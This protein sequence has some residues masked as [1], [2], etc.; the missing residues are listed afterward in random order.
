MEPSSGKIGKK[1][2]VEITFYYYPR[3]K[4]E[5]ND[6]EAVLL[7]IENGKR[8]KIQLEGITPTVTVVY[9]EPLHF[10]VIPVS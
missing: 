3:G 10:G 7:Y 6:K 8:Y 2:K 9:L 5:G 4:K 1:S